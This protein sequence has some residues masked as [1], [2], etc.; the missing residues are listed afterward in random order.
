MARPIRRMRVIMVSSPSIRFDG[1]SVTRLWTSD[2]KT[3][4]AT[5]AARVLVV[6]D[7]PNIRE[8]VCLHL[9][10]EG[11]SCEGIGD[12]QAA[13]KRADTDRFD[14]MVLDVMIP[15]LDGLSLC[16]AIRN[17]RVN[18]DVPILILTARRD[19]AD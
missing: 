8:L 11:Y 1:R 12:G 10:H 16:R 14:L 5:S 18:H 9:G 3:M 15:G 17:G 19:E 4:A 13:L 6:E 7:E 2:E